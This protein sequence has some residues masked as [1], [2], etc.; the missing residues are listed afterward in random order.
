MG[1]ISATITD[2]E[3]GDGVDGVV[4]EMGIYSAVSDNGGLFE[5]ELP[6]RTYDIRL[7]MGDYLEQWA[8]DFAVEADEINEF[9]F[10]FELSGE[11]SDEIAPM[12][13]IRVRNYPN[14][15]MVNSARGSGTTF[16][17]M[18]NF[19]K[20]IIMELGIYNIRGQKVMGRELTL[21]AGMNN[22]YWSGR[23]DH[24]EDCSAGIY[25]Y[26][27]NGKGLKERGKLL[28]LR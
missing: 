18:Q 23:N 15:L 12:E 14:P 27:L 11:T 6:A 9:N 17:I 13:L 26:Q 10:A 7:T 16:E 28:I 21:A 1:T 20:E 3:T 25:F 4:V 24:G 5:L 8:N 19:Q 2:S 22:Y